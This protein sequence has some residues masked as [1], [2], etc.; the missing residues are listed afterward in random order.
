[1]ARLDFLWQLQAR[2]EKLDMEALQVKK[3]TVCKVFVGIH[4]PIKITISE[5]QQAHPVQLASRARGH[6]LPGQPVQEQPGK[7][8]GNNS[9]DLQAKTMYVR[10]ENPKTKK[11]L[12]FHETS[13]V[14]TKS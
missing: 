11:C 4:V 13:S 6:P 1:M 7:E 14:L 10:L 12:F 2:E 5:F 3:N 8:K 9:I